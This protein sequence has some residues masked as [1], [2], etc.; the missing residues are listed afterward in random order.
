MI[1]EGWGW[2]LDNMWELW[3]GRDGGGGGGDRKRIPEYLKPY[4]LQKPYSSV[5]H[6][7]KEYPIFKVQD[8]SIKDTPCEDKSS[9][10]EDQ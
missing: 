4:C 6:I 5:A 10:R 1:L 9:E 8:T 3:W 7:F 2:L